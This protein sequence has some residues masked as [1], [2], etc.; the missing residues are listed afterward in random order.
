MIE[1]SSGQFRSAEEEQA[2]REFEKGAEEEKSVEQENQKPFDAVIVLGAG[3]E[4]PRPVWQEYLQA[5]PEEKDKVKTGWMLGKD[6]RMRTIAAAEMYRQGLVRQLIFTGGKTAESRGIQESEAEKMRDYAKH[7]LLRAGVKEEEIE[8]AITLEDKATNTIE[9][10]ANVCNIIDQN[11]NEFRHLAVLTNE[12]H[13]KRAKE[14]MQKFGLET[15]GV[16]AEEKLK[17]R[18]SKYQPVIDKFFTSD[19]YRQR[20]AGERRWLAGLENLPRY[21]FPQAMA[22]DNPKRLYRIMKSIYGPA[23]SQKLGQDA[24]LKSREGLSQ[25]ERAIPPEEWGRKDNQ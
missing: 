20:L 13:L 1:T 22:V 14:L 2:A 9:N 25:T 18:S 21:W 19:G 24:V 15:T 8:Q 17:E 12:Y 3:I 4:D 23:L 5:H 7:L 11:P 16:V 6:A 10:V